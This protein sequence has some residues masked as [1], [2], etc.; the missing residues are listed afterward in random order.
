MN[1]DK[2]KKLNLVAGID[3]IQ[4]TS[5]NESLLT[6]SDIPYI[7]KKISKDTTNGRYFYKLNPDKYIGEYI[8]D[9]EKYKLCYCCMIND[10]GL[11]NTT[12]NRVDI[13]FDSRQDNFEILEK[14]NLT[15]NLLISNE[16]NLQNR[17]K[18]FDFKTL[19]DLSIVSKSQY[20]EVESYNKAIQEPTGDIYNRLELRRKKLKGNLTEKQIFNDW[21]ETLHK[22]VSKKRYEN[23]QEELNYYLIKRYKALKTKKRQLTVNNFLCRYDDNILTRKQL[24]KF[25]AMLDYRN[26]VES[27]KKYKKRTNIEFIRLSDLQDY[28]KK[29]EQ[30]GV[31]YFG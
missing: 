13:R 30:A 19:N 27:A 9:F 18:S 23:L 20:Y 25:Y 12:L 11:Y 15:L 1:I 21:I 26:P 31:K 22:S 4:V 28:V 7:T 14:L 3:T 24:I 10:L 6:A 29:I 5:D 16:L 8:T 17:Y 2:I